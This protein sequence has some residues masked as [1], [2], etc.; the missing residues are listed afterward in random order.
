MRQPRY[1]RGFLSDGKT[2]RNVSWKVWYGPVCRDERDRKNRRQ[3]HEPGFTRLSS[4]KRFTQ[5]RLERL[6]KS[7]WRSIARRTALVIRKAVVRRATGQ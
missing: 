2:T 1:L 4:T 6:M 7:R 5:E 3:T